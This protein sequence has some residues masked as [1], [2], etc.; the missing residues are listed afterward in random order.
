MRSVLAESVPRDLADEFVDVHQ[1]HHLRLSSV[2]PGRDVAL[3]HE[4]VLVDHRTSSVFSLA[5]IGF[6]LLGN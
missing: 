1:R 4:R 6:R 3:G 5:Y 2:R